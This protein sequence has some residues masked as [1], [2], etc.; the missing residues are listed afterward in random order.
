MTTK[1]SFGPEV[2]FERFSFIEILIDLDGCVVLS[3]RVSKTQRSDV[4]HKE[5][6]STHS[7]LS[8]PQINSRAGP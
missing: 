4:H 2:R 6:V 7:E 3:H 1:D 5:V 8:L